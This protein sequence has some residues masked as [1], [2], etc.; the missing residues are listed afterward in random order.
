[1]RIEELADIA[2]ASIK[3]ITGKYASK[4]GD[5]EIGYSEGMLF[6]ELLVVNDN[7]HTGEAEG[8]LV[9]KGN[10]ALFSSK[11]P[12]CELAFKFSDKEVTL[13]Q[14]GGCGMGLNVTATGLYKSMTEAN[15]RLVIGKVGDSMESLFYAKSETIY[16]KY[17]DAGVEE[18]S[19]NIICKARNRSGED[20]SHIVHIF[21]GEYGGADGMLPPLS[22]AKKFTI[23][24]T[25]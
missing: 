15:A 14:K 23:L 21:S 10:T 16:K 22:V 2:H 24:S 19:G 17:C 3:R 7:A 8:E 11:E 4:N 5:L 9:L 13:T 12:E 20:S 6:F 18:N 25:N 1:R